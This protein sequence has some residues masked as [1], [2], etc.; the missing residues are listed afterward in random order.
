MVMEQQ[1]QQNY[2]TKKDELAKA[3]KQRRKQVKAILSIGD[4]ESNSQLR[5]SAKFLIEYLQ[6]HNF[7]VWN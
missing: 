7:Q 6:T 3:I 2:I 1:I 5:L 4:S